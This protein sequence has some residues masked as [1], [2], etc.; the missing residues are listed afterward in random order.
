MVFTPSWWHIKILWHTFIV[1]SSFINN[2]QNIAKFYESISSSQRNVMKL[3]IKL[4]H[5][6]F[7]INVYKRIF[8]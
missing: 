3:F 2:F 6:N 1:D 7:L 4:F 5:N 8:I